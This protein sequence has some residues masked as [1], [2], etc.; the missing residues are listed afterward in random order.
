MSQF[1]IASVELS[2]GIA[3]GYKFH[4]HLPDPVT[5]GADSKVKLELIHMSP[6]P[7]KPLLLCCNMAGYSAVGAKMEK[8]L[9]MVHET[10]QGYE[11][12]KL[13]VA[14]APGIYNDI[15]IELISI[16]GIAVGNVQHVAIQIGI[17]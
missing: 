6:K 15:T 16:D 11:A 5:L 3:Y 14:A 2:P 10:P 13:L 17:Y 1:I 4:N 7:S 8:V 9:S 12:S